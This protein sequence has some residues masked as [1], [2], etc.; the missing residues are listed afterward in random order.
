MTSAWGK[1][2]DSCDQHGSSWVEAA[3]VEG[4]ARL[5]QMGVWA[6]DDLCCVCLLEGS[7]ACMGHDRVVVR[8]LRP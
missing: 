1:R 8:T 6:G 7:R 2:R 3:G 4:P 5:A